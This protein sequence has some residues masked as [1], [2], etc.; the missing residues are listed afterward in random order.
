MSETL[1]MISSY[2]H[3]NGKEQ[4]WDEEVTIDTSRKGRNRICIIEGST[5][6]NLIAYLYFTK[7]TLCTFLEYYEFWMKINHFFM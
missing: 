2:L 1:S 6:A 5:I 4:W 3:N 7:T